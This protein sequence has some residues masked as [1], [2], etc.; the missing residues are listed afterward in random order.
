MLAEIIMDYYGWDEVWCAG[1]R[2]PDNPPPGRETCWLP[3]HV[4][5]SRSFMVGVLTG[6]DNDLVCVKKCS[7]DEDP[8]TF[9][10]P[11]GRSILTATLK[12]L[13]VRLALDFVDRA[14]RF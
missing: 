14:R 2:H 5:R 4:F 6:K 9:L 3:W 12:T 13:A 10:A 11:A 7:H 8:E 1:V